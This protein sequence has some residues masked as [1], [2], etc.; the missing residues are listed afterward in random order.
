VIR[1]QTFNL[2]K[3]KVDLVRPASPGIPTRSLHRGT[4]STRKKERGKIPNIE[5]HSLPVDHLVAQLVGDVLGF[6][7][8]TKLQPG[9]PNYIHLGFVGMRFQMKEILKLVE[10]GLDPQKGLAQVNKDIN[11]EDRIRG[12][13]KHLNPPSNE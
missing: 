8:L 4:R 2:P 10:V 6:L 5:P 7:S 11:V 9:S 3:E 1:L 13:V 12:Q